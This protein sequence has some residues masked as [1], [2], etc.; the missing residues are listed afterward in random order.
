ML[1]PTNSKH[2][3]LTVSVCK[4]PTDEAAAWCKERMRGGGDE[5]V[6]EG[7][8]EREPAFFSFQNE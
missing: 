4:D 2:V 6:E 8:G 1:L 5:A 7:G 3:L